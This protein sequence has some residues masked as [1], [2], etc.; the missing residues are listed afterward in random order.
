MDSLL[1][2]PAESR[3]R[4][5][6]RQYLDTQQLTAAQAALEALVRR[7]PQEASF[8][9]ELAQVM[10]KRGRLQAAT[11]QWL[12]VTRAPLP[13]DPGLIL[14]LAQ[15]LCH[16]GEVR[17]ARAC[18]DHLSQLPDAPAEL[19]AEQARLRST[20]G[21][22]P[23]SKAAMARALAAGIDTP[24]D[25]YLYAML[26]QFSGELSRAEE[27]LEECLRRWPFFGGAVMALA[28]LRKQTPGRNHLD[29]LHRQLHR[30]PVD[31]ATPSD[32]LVRAEFEAA[33]FKELDDLGRHAEAWPALARSNALMH[34]LN[35]YDAVLET[36]VTDA[37]VA[38]SGLVG[39][40]DSRT[41]PQLDGPTPIF[42]VGMPRSGT[43]LLERMLSNHSEVTS[44][45]ELNDFVRQFHWVADILP[46]GML[47]AIQ[48]SSELDYAELGA[49]YLRQT[50]WR[51]HG[52]KYYVDKLP[53]NIQMVAFIRK[54]L[55]HAV[56]LH[57]VREP[58]EVCFSNYRAMFGSVSA[59][60]Y[61][62][63]AL[64][65]YYGQYERLASHWRTT[66]PEALLEVSY[67]EL[68]RTPEP[69]LRRVLEYCG[70]DLEELCL[71]PEGNVAP[72]A[73]PS[74]IQV[75]EPI[76][77]RSLGQW[78]NYSEQLEP[79]RMMLERDAYR[80]GVVP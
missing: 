66:L 14:Q 63:A 80:A 6:V 48:R 23:A 18:L 31:G 8:R 53:A 20:L 60:S 30:F 33:V 9:M 57:M 40:A 42:I 12:Q 74:N 4:R 45:G 46:G 51:A 37:L 26:F 64:A 76:H 2:S 77:T 52:H 19:W 5:R 44:A 70:L 65:H 58:M 50:Q 39:E 47:Q 29:F 36:V 67:T 21:E 69:T 35:P 22:L 73:T 25:H 54:A 49:R 34:A 16:V 32:N 10:L 59:Y 79:L 56:I 13:D 7:V 55:P 3:L 27:I 1:L 28:N 61:D 78:R 17:A 68:V 72:V 38:H 62:M 75:R 15:H 41:A 43:T 24:D 71:R 11:N